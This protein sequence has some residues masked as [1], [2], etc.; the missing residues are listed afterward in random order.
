GRTCGGKGGMAWLRR[1][2][3]VTWIMAAAL[4]M[5]VMF[6]PDRIVV[7]SDDA[8]PV[9]QS[10]FYSFGRDGVLMWGVDR[11][12]GLH[13]AIAHFVL[14]T[15]GL[16]YLVGH[17]Y[18]LQYQQALFLL[19]GMT[20]LLRQ[21]STWCLAAAGMVVMLAL[22]GVPGYEHLNYWLGRVGIAY[23]MIMLSVF[24]CFRALEAHINRS[25]R[26]GWTW[27]GLTC[28]TVCALVSSPGNVML[29]GT[30]FAILC[31]T[32]LCQ[33]RRIWLRLLSGG[34]AIAI[35]GAGAWWVK[36]W[37]D[38][39]YHAHR[40]VTPMGFEWS[41]WWATMGHF[42]ER[43]LKWGWL[44]TGIVVA[45]VGIVAFI[46]MLLIVGRYHSGVRGWMQGMR[47][48][49]WEA[50][51]I[52]SGGTLY[53]VLVA[54]HVW[55]H[56]NPQN[57]TYIIPSFLS[58]CG[59]LFIISD[60]VIERLPQRIQAVLVVLACS[61]TLGVVAMKRPRGASSH[62]RAAQRLLERIKAM[63]TS[64]G[65]MGDF[66]HVC[67]Y[68][69]FDPHR[70]MSCSWPHQLL[71][72]AMLPRMHGQGRIL[73]DFTGAESMGF[74]SQAAP[75]VCV[76]RDLVLSRTALTLPT[77]DN[78]WYIYRPVRESEL[79]WEENLIGPPVQLHG[80]AQLVGGVLRITGGGEL[81]C[82]LGRLVP[83]DYLLKVSAR[84]CGQVTEITPLVMY[85]HDRELESPYEHL[86]VPLHVLEGGFKEF[87]QHM[88]YPGAEEPAR[89][90]LYAYLSGTIEVNEIGLYKLPVDETGLPQQ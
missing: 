43:L 57:P 9:L 48:R 38:H 79:A 7:N 40:Q 44:Y 46:P 12:G 50:F 84:A 47:E 59:A 14:E 41:L 78:Y 27:L 36:G 32:H 26:T 73:V 16:R 19:L 28:A 31:C 56:K 21:W 49:L 1:A 55:V 17:R 76:F 29:L 42:L 5:V 70:L 10:A 66:W 74:S 88:H 75:A 30:W 15:L 68:S 18:Y 11:I 33:L 13:V 61:V 90:R 71:G 67:H 23:P 39:A 53:L 20:V 77:G 3:V 54:A 80:N 69:F 85:V 52:A 45:G 4:L 34:A 2:G 82:E 81:Y 64:V 65:L 24:A 83:G 72:D 86:V 58:Y 8:W 25:A 37:Y 89:V 62:Y 51:T 87:L 6:H 60:I 22:P 35:G 63:G